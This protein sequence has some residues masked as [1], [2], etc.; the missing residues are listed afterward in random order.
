L[1]NHISGN[2]NTAIGDFALFSD[3]GGNENTAIGASA[4]INNSTG[5]LNTA[6]G[7]EAGTGVT[8][9]DHVICIGTAGAN[10]N[11]DGARGSE[12]AV[13]RARDKN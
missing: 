10:V 12:C 2:A 9:A 4:L 11:F 6:V 13:E 5:F 7:R 1:N 8:T 3:S